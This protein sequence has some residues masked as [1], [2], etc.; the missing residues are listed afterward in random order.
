MI[1]TTESEC[2]RACWQRAGANS[3]VDPARN[4]RAMLV[5][6]PSGPEG[7]CAPPHRFAASWVNTGS[8]VRATSGVSRRVSGRDRDTWPGYGAH[9][10]K[11]P[12]RRSPTRRSDRNRGCDRPSGVGLADSV[13]CRVAASGLRA[14]AS[15]PADRGGRGISSSWVFMPS[16]LFGEA[17]PSQQPRRDASHTFVNSLRCDRD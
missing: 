5:R 14:C 12:D 1:G 8:R 2:R 4:G 11:R 10:P 7:P 15:R 17:H 13:R 9:D 6:V 16:C 3:V